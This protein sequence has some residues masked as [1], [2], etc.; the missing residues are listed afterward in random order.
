MQ[1]AKGDR[2][3][4]AAGPGFVIFTP[5]LFDVTDEV[6]VHKAATEVRSHVNKHTLLG[7]VNNAGA[8]HIHLCKSQFLQAQQLHCGACELF[9]TG[10]P[11]FPSNRK[12][13][14]KIFTDL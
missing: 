2:R 12:Q 7:L 9:V 8:P 1:R 4:V 3:T 14:K 6:A 11:H 13:K 10:Y 5:L